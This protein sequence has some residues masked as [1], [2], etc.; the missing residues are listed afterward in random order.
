MTYVAWAAVYEGGTDEVYFELLIPRIMEEIV[1][2]HGTR[3]STIPT[4]PAVRLHRGTVEKVAQE[5]CA[6]RDAFHLVFIHA[7]TGGRAME[8]DSDRRS[9]RYC[10]AM[11]AVCE[12]PPARCIVISPR[13]ET[14]AWMLADPFAVT[15]AFGYTGPPNSI[16]LPVNAS[17]AER[18]ENPKETLAAAMIQVRGRRRRPDIRQIIPAIAQ[19]QSLDNLRRSRSFTSFEASLRVALGDLGCI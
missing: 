6:A 12:W 7:D 4:A 18:L 1:R 16:G 19:R 3:S 5:V 15:G 8:S 13:H 9:I 10:E 17:D 2:L 11:H 14:E